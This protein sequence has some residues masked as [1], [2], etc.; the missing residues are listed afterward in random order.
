MSN[1]WK[2]HATAQMLADDKNAL[3]IDPAC[4]EITLQLQVLPG[5][6]PNK[7]AIKRHY[8]SI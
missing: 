3:K 7:S 2:S 8:V 5:S 6:D 1:C 4:K